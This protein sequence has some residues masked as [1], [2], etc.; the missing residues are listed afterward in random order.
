[1]LVVKPDRRDGCV[2]RGRQKLNE[3]PRTRN[4]CSEDVPARRGMTER[5]L[6]YDFVT[7]MPSF[8]IIETLV[9]VSREF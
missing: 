7:E 5:S 6:S 3:A 4:L 2:A 8:A 1:M 9:G